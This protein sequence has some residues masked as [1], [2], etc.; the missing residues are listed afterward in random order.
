MSSYLLYSQCPG[1]VKTCAVPGILPNLFHLILTKHTQR[2][3]VSPSF[4]NRTLRLGKVMIT[5]IQSH[6]GI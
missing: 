1:S 5:Q 6:A 4:I 2:G 3:M